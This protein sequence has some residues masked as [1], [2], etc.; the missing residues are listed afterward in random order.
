MSGC[1][2]FA[3]LEALAASDGERADDEA[4][5]HIQ[6]CPKCSDRLAQI[7][8]NAAL[9]DEC[10]HVG[11]EFLRDVLLSDQPN[12][13]ADQDRGGTEVALS[14]H[15]AHAPHIEGY[16]ILA[17]IHRGAQGVVYEAVQEAAN[18][19]VA[20]KVLLR[21]RYASHRER[22]RFER[23]I[24]LV[25]GLSHP[26][27][28][29]LFDSGEAEGH[30]YFAMQYVD[31]LR[32]ADH[33]IAHRLGID[34]TLRMV[35]KVCR[36]MAYAHQRGVI[37]RDLKP[38]NIHVDAEGEPHVLDFGLARPAHG[39]D[40]VRAGMTVTG[41]FLGTIRYASPE[42]V[43]G[44]HRQIDTRTDVYSLGVILYELVTGR[45]PY[46]LA[47]SMPDVLKSITDVAP[48]RPSAIR[49]EIDDDVETIILKAISKEKDRRYHSAEALAQDLERALAGKPIEA[50]SDSGM[51][52]LRKTLARHRGP[53]VATLAVVVAL[54]AALVVALM[55]GGQAAADRD[56]AVEAERRAAEQ[57]DIA[58]ETAESLRRTTYMQQVALAQAALK[59]NN[60]GLVRRLLADCPPDLRS[61]E[62]HH[63]DWLRDRSTATAEFHDD[64]LADVDISP[65]ESLIAVAGSKVPARILEPATNAKAPGFRTVLE[66]RSDGD[67]GGGQYRDAEA[68]A[69]SPDGRTV[70]SAGT[71]LVVHLWSVA[72]GKEIRAFT[73]HEGHPSFPN[74][75][76]QSVAWSPDGKRLA[77]AGWDKTIRLW[78][79]ETGH[80][81]RVMRGHD[82]GVHHVT[83]SPDG[84]RIVSASGDTTI[85]MWDATTGNSVQT[86]VGHV[87]TVE[88]TGS[89]PDGRYIASGGRDGTVRLWDA[90]TGEAIRSFIGHVAAVYDLAFAPTGTH[91]VSGGSDR[92]VRVWNLDT[93][94]QVAMLR[95]HQAR[96]RGV[97]FLSDGM[98]LVT[99]G[100][101][102]VKAWNLAG[103]NDVLEWRNKKTAQFNYASFSPDGSRFVTVGGE[104]DPAVSVWNATAPD[105]PPTVLRGHDKGVEC[106]VFSPDGT[107]IASGGHDRTVIL[108]D[109]QTGRLMHTLIGHT[110]GVSI[111][112]FSPDGQRL[113]SGS[114]DGTCTIW[115][116][117]SHRPVRSLEHAA[118]VWDLAC[119]PDGRWIA[120]GTEDGAL[121]V[122]DA[123]TG[124]RTL[125]LREDTEPIDA[126]AFSP[127]S[128]RVT[129]GGWSG[130]LH[131]ASIPSGEQ[132]QTIRT[133]EERINSAVFS[134]DGRRIVIGTPRAVQLWDPASERLAMEMRLNST[135][136]L[137]V[138]FSPDRTRLLA[139]STDGTCRIW[140]ARANDESLMT[141]AR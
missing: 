57:R 67:E 120:T 24:D 79:V 68:V 109:A 28:V 138:Q 78:D 81:I 20:L 132:V 105:E 141:N 66:V 51:Y 44:E 115:D 43:A 26:H 34:E 64:E 36:A 113:V 116:M 19:T 56:R 124:G 41:A 121:S 16:T 117:K 9:M 139:A 46:R 38:G 77:S 65:R 29:T 1:L 55:F 27:I 47:G 122:W 23:E 100:P 92:T 88:C 126:V 73:G 84:R 87:G 74:H 11:A 3:E 48:V 133:H 127:D 45:C 13:V 61:W 103:A 15:P 83:F 101:G 42:Q 95:G 63:L 89:S 99:A 86:L 135:S 7:R 90:T 72:T 30:Q 54:A 58:R 134:P 62:W 128:A 50:R 10:R 5:R 4:G 96:V 14:D 60:V 91:L 17:E 102:E 136:V 107:W 71:D 12:D 52:V 114:W 6:S 25:A 35:V 108:W 76:I 129:W 111:L 22:L 123:A 70:A 53:V 21:G 119:S 59:E 130:S 140:T 8:A 82:G 75:H 32:L 106:A 33:V 137:S 98:Q 97:A 39:S 2:T 94:K 110:D 49:P 18:R 85:R 69:F 37:H 118:E 112:A 104:D 80:A 131:V 40:G 93:G 31:G 125:H